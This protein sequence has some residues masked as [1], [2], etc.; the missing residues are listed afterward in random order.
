MADDAIGFSIEIP[1][2]VFSKLDKVDEKIKSLD[3]TAKVLIH[4]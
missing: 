1:D 2:S 3:A 4:Y